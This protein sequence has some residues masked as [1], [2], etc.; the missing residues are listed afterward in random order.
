VPV[1]VATVHPGEREGGC[2]GVYRTGNE[3]WVVT[4]VQGGT[5][6][7]AVPVQG[8][9]HG[10]VRPLAVPG[11]IGDRETDLPAPPHGP[12]A[13]DHRGLRGTAQAGRW[14]RLV[15]QANRLVQRRPAGQHLGVDHRDPATHEAEQGTRPAQRHERRPPTY[16]HIRP[17]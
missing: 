11:R 2:P 7:R 15:T 14:G 16:P 4:G 12:E 3:V 9:A 1:P 10:Q 17:A 5:A 8:Q 13:A 6:V